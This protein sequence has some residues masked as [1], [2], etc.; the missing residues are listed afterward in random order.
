NGGAKFKWTGPDL[1]SAGICTDDPANT[2]DKFR[3]IFSARCFTPGPG[4]TTDIRNYKLTTFDLPSTGLSAQPNLQA[5]ASF[6]QQYHLGSHYGVFEFGGKIRNEH[7]FDDSTQ[8]EADFGST[9]PAAQFV[10]TFTD[11]NY[12]DKTYHFTNTPDYNMV[13]TFALA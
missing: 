6:A 5:S 2:P 11:P 8:L 4:D 1:G 10:G 12:Y 3:P 13:K 9:V 7:K